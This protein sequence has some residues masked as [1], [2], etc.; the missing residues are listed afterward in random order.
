MILTLWRASVPIT[1][2]YFIGTNLVQQI[3]WKDYYVTCPGKMWINDYS[4]QIVHLTQ[5]KEAVLPKYSLASKCVSVAKSSQGE[6]KLAG[7]RLTYRQLHHWRAYPS[8]HEDLQTLLP[9]NSCT[10]CI[11][12]PWKTFSSSVAVYW[13]SKLGERSFPSLLICMS[14][15][16]SRREFPFGGNNYLT[17][18]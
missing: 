10:S 14:C 7:L 2:N 4:R 5:T 9:L 17:C 3:T 11:K 13:L 12:S 6:K 1:L 16:P 15:P 18:M 8:T